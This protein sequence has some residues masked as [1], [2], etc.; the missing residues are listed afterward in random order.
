MAEALHERPKEL[1]ERWL[2]QQK[3]LDF[4]RHSCQSIPTL[5][6]VRFVL[7]HRQRV[8]RRWCKWPEKLRDQGWASGHL[9]NR[10]VVLH[11]ECL[12]GSLPLVTNAEG[13]RELEPCMDMRCLRH[14]LCAGKVTYQAIRDIGEQLPYRVS[15]QNPTMIDSFSEGCKSSVSKKATETAATPIS[16]TDGLRYRGV[17]DT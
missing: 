14:E 7:I 1:D 8:K 17:S 9:H 11:F 2:V 12:N 6:V 10:S 13:P 16:P 4:N 3:Q 15:D 5:P